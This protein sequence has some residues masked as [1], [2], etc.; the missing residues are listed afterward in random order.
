MAKI[1]L[2][3]I[4][5]QFQG[6]FD[7]NQVYRRDDIVYHNNA[8]YIMTNEY[9]P[10]GTNAYAPGTKIF[11]Y[12]P[13]DRTGEWNND[14][15]FMGGTDA[16]NYTQYWTENERRAERQRTDMD[17][18]PITRNSTYGSNEEGAHEIKHDIVDSTLGSVVRH[19]TH[20][21]DEYDSMFAETE[22]DYS[23]EDTYNKYEQTYFRYH[24]R[25]VEHSFIVQVAVSGG[26][27]DFKIDNRLGD[28]TKGRQFA[29]YRNWEFFKEGHKY[30]FSQHDNNNKYYPLGFS[31]TADG[32]HNANDLGKSLG[33]DPRGPY[34]V[35]GTTSAGDSGFF[36][37][38]Y[39]DEA[40]AIAEDT[41]RGGAGVAHALTFDQGDVPGWETEASPSLKGHLHADGTQRKDTIVSLLTDASNNTYLQVTNAWKG[42]TKGGTASSERKTI[43]INTG[44]TT[45]HHSI[46]GST[47][48]Y[49][50]VEGAL[51]VGS[52]I[53][54]V[55]TQSRD[56]EGTTATGDYAGRKRLLINGKPVY[57]L[58][59]EAST[60]AVGGIAGAY[61]AIDKTGTGSTT[62]LGS[63]P[64][65]NEGKVVLYMPKMTD[66][67]ANTE[68]TYQISVVSSKFH[69]DG[70]LPD[71]NTI[72]LEEGKTY[73]FDQSDSTNDTH[74]LAFSTTSNGTHGGGAEYTSGVTYVGTPGQKGA[75]TQIKVRSGVAK[76]YFYCKAHS[77]M[78]NEAETYD[79]A[80]NLGKTFAPANIKKWRGYGKN[81]FVK[82]YLDGHQ[83]DEN[84]YVDSFFMAD[85]GATDDHNYPRTMDNGKVKGGRQYNFF[86][87]ASRIVELEV[88][89]QNNQ[90]ESAQ[91]K[92]Y[93]FCLEPTTTA[94]Q[95][96]GMYNDKG[97]TIEKSWRG[98]KHW[99]KIQSSM[100]FR[101]EY[102]PNTEYNYNDIVSYK[103]FKRISTGEKFY[104]HGTGL[105]RAIRDN[106]GRPPQHG[107]Q[108]ETRSPMMTNSTVTSNRLTGYSQYEDNNET[109]K[110]YPAHIQS[111]HNC[112]ESFAGMN[113][114]EQCAGAWFP[115]KGPIAW[116]YKHGNVESANIYRCHMFIDKNGAVWTLG[117]GSSSHNME[118]G[119]SSSYF[120]EVCFRWRD[121]Y[122]SENRNEGGYNER[123]GSKWTRYDRMRTPRAVQIEMSYDATM[124]LFDNGEVFHGGYGSHGN[125]GTGYDGAPGMAMSPDGLENVHA[126]KIAMKHQNEDSTHTPAIL[127]DEGSVW[128]WGYNGYGECGDGRTQNNYGP[129]R[130]PAEFFND[131]KIIDITVSGGDSSSFYVR[132]SQDNIYAWGRNNIGQLGDTT[133]TDKY[134]PVLQTGF[135]ASDNS[136]IA[137][138]AALSHSSNSS[139]QILDGNGYIWSTGYNGYAH[140]FDNST[141]NRTQMTQATA[142][143]AGDIV[144]MWSLRWN[145]YQT[146][147]VRLKNGQTWTA[148]H[149][150]GYYN[151]GDGGTGTNTAPVQV[152]K[153]NNLKE[154]NICNT[155][156]DQGR[157]YW[158]QDNG[159]MFS[160]GR[161][162]YG[163]MPNPLAGDNWN[164]EDG[165]YKPFHSFVPAGTRIKTMCIQG[166]DQ[167]TNYYGLQPWV[168]TE[169]GQ[170]LM[171]GYSNNNNLGHHAT[172]T[173]S[174]TGRSMMLNPGI[175][176]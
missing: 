132:T 172:A 49:V 164:G 70:A 23:S 159:E 163:S 84:T 14:P 69:I 173:Y 114:Q 75:Y 108:G 137:V 162:V 87:K 139:F 165:T 153:I 136:G 150:G 83:V 55:V 6:E 43:Y 128:T 158:L 93:P 157:S 34:Y 155:Y 171:W 148:G 126:I 8:M 102:S 12:N 61:Q 115:N 127:D 149:S 56:D 21:M 167:S 58:V 118:Q 77:G 39:K 103:P 31:Y 41:S 110:N 30:S 1:N 64:T 27:P 86:N 2:G 5:L 116:P 53:S 76:L 152:D 79:T 78:G 140:F 100:R 17:G 89:Y 96:S 174:S 46:T 35:K 29:G 109:G 138:W 105:Y 67:T 28:D 24:Y 129:K 125:Q 92:I 90:V 45:E 57:Q 123:R 104:K 25:P 54:A 98:H 156:S 135:N 9:L 111:Y 170:T 142:S 166:I 26:V 7:K 22:D 15:N 107:F 130:I 117:H 51:K 99:D 44:D 3:R 60:T 141:T 63:S 120:R 85:K 16:F 168:G 169:D 144:D 143:P 94:R 32:I 50:Y 48:S 147:F 72:K 124:I 74:T 95:T 38:M 13:K 36:S 40:A 10:D 4:K 133:S 122:N 113:N 112:W 101:G 65:S 161:D 11:G 66:P 131:E 151:S 42:S 160:Q 80:T 68:R 62:A 37:P 119:R 145:G 91:T 121:F 154:V 81:G 47:Y 146:T 59:A 97:W 175:G 106:K 71:A 134:R 19:Q 18:N 73:K 52:N 176:R 82:Y 33:E 88:P 20:L